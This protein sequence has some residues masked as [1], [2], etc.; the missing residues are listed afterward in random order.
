MSEIQEEN[1]ALSEDWFIRCYINGL[2]EGIKYQM[3]PLRPATLTD[4]FCLARDVEPCHP[5]VVASTKRTSVPYNNYYQ[6][7]TGGFIQKQPVVPPIQQQIPVR[8]NETPANNA[9]KIRKLGECWR[10]GDNWF[11]GHKCKQALVI[12]VLTGE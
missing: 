5:P 11:H 1:P 6:K 2:R 4:A 7:N 10:C 9:Q 12:N 3:R 8:H